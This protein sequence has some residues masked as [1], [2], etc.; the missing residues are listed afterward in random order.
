[1]SFVLPEN[2]TV[3]RLQGTERARL[4]Y[5]CVTV[6]EPS[7]TDVKYLTLW[8]EQW[9]KIDFKKRADNWRG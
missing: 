5:V 4:H 1:M 6:P 9:K 2:W 8:K 7:S 3:K